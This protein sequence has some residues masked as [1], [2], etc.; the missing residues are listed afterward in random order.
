MDGTATRPAYPSTHVAD[1]ALRDGSTVRIRPVRDRDRAA[2]RAFLD[3]LSQQSL[4]LRFFGTPNLDWATNWSIDV[5]YSDRYALVAT[6]GHDQEI[7][8]HGAYVRVDESRAEVAFTISDSW[9]GRGIATIMLLHLAAVADEHGIVAFVAEVL[10]HNRRML[11]VFGESGFSLRRRTREGV[12]ELELPTSL[13]VQARERLEKREQTAAI[14]AVASFLQPRAVAVIGASRRRRTVG[15][16]ILHNLLAGDFSGAVYPVNAKARTVQALRAYRAVGEVPERVDLAVIAVPAAQVTDVAEECAAAG[17]RALLVISAGFAEAGR[18]GARRQDALLSACREAGMRLIGPNCLGVFN[19][20]PDVGLNATFAARAPLPGRVSFLS[21]SGGL[22]IAIV[23]AA[24][25]LGLGL[26]SFVSVGNKADISGNDLL[27]FWERDAATDVVLLYLESFGNPRRFARIARRVSATKPIV[28]VKSGRSPAGARA[29][30]SH[31]GALVSSSDV[32]V[33]ALFRQAGVIRTDTMHELFDV[34]SLLSNQPAPHGARVAI[35]TNAGGPGIL[36][37]DACQAGELEVP[38]LPAK[39][40]RRLA[41]LLPDEASVENPIDM[42]ATCPAA[43]YRDTIEALVQSEACDALIAIFVPPLV[44]EARDAAR[45]IQAA[46]AHRGSARPVTVAAVFMGAEEP[47]AELAGDE[48]RIPTFAFPEDA[49]RAMSH[50]VRYARWRARPTGR[51]PH[52]E[53]C[54]PLDATAIVARALA[55]GAGWMGPAD[56]AALLDCYRLPLIPARIVEDADA[57]LA[58]AA[59]LGEPVALKAVAPGLLHK[60]DAGG[61]LL[62]LRGPRALR[63]GVRK[64]QTSVSAAGHDLRGLIVQPMAPSGL[65]LLMGVV[66]D[67]SFGPVLACGAGGTSAELLRDVAVRITPLS[68]LDARE[69]LRALRTF[70]L[71]AGYRGAPA[72]DIAA[73]EDILHRLSALVEAHP[74][75]AELDFNPVIAR[76]FGAVILDARVR[77]SA[78]PPRRPFAALKG[79]RDDGRAPA[80]LRRA[81]AG[82]RIPRA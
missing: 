3:S 32:T 23:E 33:D 62:G 38:R 14:A 44:T 66:H 67:E 78:P 35:V 54:R 37:A 52:P 18:E 45:E 1:V 11:D 42:L 77:L 56:V 2:V 31:T 43:S 51:I 81:R 36:C 72:C 79:G 19:T 75:V 8:G 53:G 64:I 58:A 63:A 55:G 49:A 68:D 26:S 27:Q 28:A 29:G 13:S 7:V 6:S 24:Q 5:D 21:Q 60:S 50:A 12:I 69:M 76:P 4:A 82:G 74:E 47:P 17:V 61:V 46:L 25:R 10:P 40:R 59:E 9:Q 48:L 71:L 22:G 57:V 70:P 16:E 20:A 39:V 34:A 41:G 65:E 30:A 15:G 80:R 73:V